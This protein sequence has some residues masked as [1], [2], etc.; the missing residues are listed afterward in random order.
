MDERT[1]FFFAKNAALYDYLTMAQILTRPDVEKGF[2]TFSHKTRTVVLG[3]QLS[4][5]SD[6]YGC[7]LL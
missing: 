1:T 2:I 4:N 3:I 7:N 5:A 6:E